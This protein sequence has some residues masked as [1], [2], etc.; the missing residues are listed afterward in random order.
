MQVKAENKARALGEQFM[1]KQL[2]SEPVLENCHALIDQII[3][4]IS[5]EKPFV[6]VSSAAELLL[7]LELAASTLKKSL[8]ST[9]TRPRD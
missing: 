1:L 9:P 4:R 7:Y 8:R 5:V 6:S 2:E 3:D